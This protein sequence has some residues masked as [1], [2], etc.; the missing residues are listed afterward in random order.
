MINKVLTKGDRRG[1]FYDLFDEAEAAEL[2]MRAQL[3]N[4]LQAWM[5]SQ[6]M[7]QS[8]IGKVLGI[9]QPRVSGLRNGNV[10]RFSLDKLVQMAQRAGL[11]PQL[12]IAS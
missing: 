11:K 4:A 10:A 8:E 7:S 3:V 5:D 1:V 12:R 2:V 9:D 6:A